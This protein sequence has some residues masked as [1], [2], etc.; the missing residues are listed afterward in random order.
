MKPAA[1]FFAMAAAA[2]AVA[3]VG[4]SRGREG[5]KTGALPEPAP[6]GVDALDTIEI[7]GIATEADVLARTVWGE[8]RGEGERGMQAVANVVLNRLRVS[9]N[10]AGRQAW[11]ET[12]REICQAP[13]Q[14]SAWSVAPWNGANLRAMLSVTPADLQFRQA[15]QIAFFAVGRALPDITGGALNYYAAR[16]PNAIAPPSWARAP[17]RKVSSIGNHDFWG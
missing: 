1:P 16:G 14:F 5:E 3:Y 12:I 2:F 11:G 17:L 7:R 6:T 15:Q 9:E 8:A 13:N 4:Y 10:A